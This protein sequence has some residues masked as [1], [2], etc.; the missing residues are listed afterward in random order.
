MMVIPDYRKLVS[1]I[2]KGSPAHQEDKAGQRNAPHHGTGHIDAAGRADDHPK[3]WSITSVPL[4]STGRIS[5][6]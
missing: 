3:S 4:T 1:A 6:R 2:R 5:F